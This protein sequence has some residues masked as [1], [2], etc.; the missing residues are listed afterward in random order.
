MMLAKLQKNKVG[1]L[2]HIPYKKIISEWI[3]D[4]NLRTKSIILLEENIGGNFHDFE[5]E[6]N[7]F[8]S[9]TRKT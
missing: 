1:P 2:Y 3:N 7:C 4:L 6:D 5:L 8:S 9:I